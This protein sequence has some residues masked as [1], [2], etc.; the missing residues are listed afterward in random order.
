[1]TKGLLPGADDWGNWYHGPDNNPVSTDTALKWPYLSQWYGTPFH[2]P[3]PINAVAA[4][5]RLFSVCGVNYPNWDRVTKPEDCLTL[6]AFNGYN[7]QELWRRNLTRNFHALSSACIATKDTVYLAE[8]NHVLFLDTA[9]GAVKDRV[10]FDGIPRNLQGRWL[11]VYSNTLFMLAGPTDGDLVRNPWFR[12]DETSNTSESPWR[13]G[14]YLGAYDLIA[15]TTLWVHVESTD[16][17][18]RNIGVAFGRLFFNATGPASRQGTVGGQ[19]WQPPIAPEVARAGCLDARTGAIL[20]TNDS[21]GD[22][23]T[24][25]RFSG[26]YGSLHR[27]NSGLICSSNF[28]SMIRLGR[29]NFVVLSAADGT[30]LWSRGVLGAATTVHYFM[31]NS[32]LYVQGLKL[33]E[34]QIIDPMTGA[35]LS[36]WS[37]GSTCARITVSPDSWYGGAGRGGVNGV[38]VPVMGMKS[39][40]EPGTFPANGLLYSIP[41]SCGCDVSGRGFV[42]AGPA[43][44]GFV[45]GVQANGAERLEYADPGAV[46]PYPVDTLDWW[47]YRA[48]NRRSA[49]L[50]VGVMNTTN[51]FWRYT[52][53]VSYLP[54]PP[55][56]AGACVFIGGS[57]GKVRCLNSATGGIQWE[58]IT[59]GKITAT[60]TVS[61]GRV[62]VGSGDGRVY[63]LEAATGQAAV[64]IPRVPD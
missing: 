32:K 14:S 57:D 4:G 31:L 38:S 46:A 12:H 1:M 60:P 7:G 43:G 51:I 45:W 23:E 41:T 13:F 20:W 52:P 44:T 9:T 26:A 49:S 28:V 6:R 18:A 8:T 24:I 62:F 22:V 63:A 56:V 17:D 53:S 25:N 2:G 47:T 29:T 42:A 30:Q 58:F 48:N 19:G 3:M 59:G 16:I 40:C 64:E 50:P 10:W 36:T 35:K 37:C 61:D 5:G 34:A 33:W 54:T 27:A 11:A 55:I 15:K 21:P 39:S